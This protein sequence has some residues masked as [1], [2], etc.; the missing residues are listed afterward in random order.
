MPKVVPQ[1]REEAKSRILETATRVFSE[2]GYHE[3][4]M[5]DVAEGMGVS[6]G[7]LYLYFGSKEELFREICKA[8]PT[9]LG[10]TLRSSFT[11]DDLVASSKAF[12]EKMMKHSF[13]ELGLNF[14]T[15]AEAS[16]NATIRKILEESYE[17]VSDVLISFLEK[18]KKEG[19]ISRGIDSR[20]LA[21]TLIAVYDGLLA[22]LFM[23]NSPEEAIKLWEDSIRFLMYGIAPGRVSRRTC[24]RLTLADH[25]PD[26]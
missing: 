9:I 13:D 23:G 24:R 7:A 11:G 16:R 22:S 1:Y 10:E 20:S 17:K 15:L 18:L 4:T 5:E 21:R 25:G 2:K 14:E 8:A 6:K 26:N 12:F 19:K 3:T